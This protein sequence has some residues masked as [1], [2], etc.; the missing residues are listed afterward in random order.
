[1]KLKTFLNQYDGVAKLFVGDFPDSALLGTIHCVAESGFFTTAKD[2]DG[3]VDK[4]NIAFELI[5]KSLGLKV[6]RFFMALTN[7]CPMLVIYLK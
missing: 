1:M 2:Y 3:N 5:E 7:D 6:N 4:A